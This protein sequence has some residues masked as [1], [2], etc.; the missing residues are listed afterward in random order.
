MIDVL[1]KSHLPSLLR[2]RVRVRVKN[3]EIFTPRREGEI[4]LFTISS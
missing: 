3:Q 1:V 2:E 4:L